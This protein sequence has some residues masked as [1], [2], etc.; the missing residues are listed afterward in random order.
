[1]AVTEVQHTSDHG[2]P[3]TNPHQDWPTPV[4]ENN[5]LIAVVCWSTDGGDATCR[6]PTGWLLAREVSIVSK[7]RQA[8][9]YKIA[10]A[11]EVTR[12]NATLS[13]SRRWN[14]MLVETHSTAPN[15]WVLD[16]RASVANS[17]TKT[18]SPVSGTTPVTTTNEEYWLASISCNDKATLSAPTNGFA[19][20][21]QQVQGKGGYN[22]STCVLSK[23]VAATAAASTGGTYDAA[24]YQVGIIATFKAAPQARTILGGTMTGAGKLS[25]RGFYAEVT[26]IVQ[27]AFGYGAREAGPVWT[28][29]SDYVR[30]V[31]WGRGRQNEL[32]Q[33]E[34]GTATVVINDEESH[35]DPNNTGS[36]LY[37]D[38]K[39]GLPVRA[40]LFYRSAMYPLFYGFTERV[41][42]TVRVTSVYTQRQLELSDGF[43][44]LAN[45]GLGGSRY[46]EETSDS[47]ANAVCNYIGWPESDRLIGVGASVLQA[48]EF[49][50]NDDTR[51]QAH[52]Q[53]VGDSENGLLFVDGA[54][55]LRF[56][57]RHEILLD[58]NYTVPK[59]TFADLL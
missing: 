14:M 22:V 7:V 29:I 13:A 2:G 23:I 38:V 58:E 37:P 54:K 46:G 48:K 40:M 9:F 1:M 26:L 12:V 20:V 55:N 25:A 5:L 18:T 43:T 31:A 33:M 50:D 57:G 27:A 28:N 10:T 39:P 52:L 17:T 59:A 41:P 49:A 21:E 32:G 45:A 35:W 24:Q 16:Q 51:A 34:A 56:V 3:D 36:P 6:L 44:L 53:G 8:V 15:G 4:T 47:R 19:I 30:T 11:S 42:R